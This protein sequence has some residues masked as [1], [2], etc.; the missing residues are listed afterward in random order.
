MLADAHTSGYGGAALAVDATLELSN[1]T[2]RNCTAGAAGGGLFALRST[3]ALTDTSFVA[4]SAATHGGGVA[5]QGYNWDVS[6]ATRQAMRTL[7]A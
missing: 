4:N 6:Q 3:V 5:A 1:A 2:V 7:Q